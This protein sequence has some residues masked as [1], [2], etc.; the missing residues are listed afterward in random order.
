[1]VIVYIALD[2]DFFVLLF[3]NIIVVS[4]WTNIYQVIPPFPGSAAFLS[5]IFKFFNSSSFHIMSGFFSLYLHVL[6]F[7]SLELP[8]LF[9]AIFSSLGTRASF[10][11]WMY[12]ISCCF[13]F[14]LLPASAVA[15]PSLW[16][17][18]LPAIRIF[19]HRETSFQPPLTQGQSLWPTRLGPELQQGWSLIWWGIIL[20]LWLLLP[21]LKSCSAL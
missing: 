1:M 2:N 3:T 19:P 9:L 7:F 5:L 11:F 13:V 10:G 20:Q 14:S 21:S 4:H 18:Q 15:V 8:L 17:P 16:L 12:F 6:L